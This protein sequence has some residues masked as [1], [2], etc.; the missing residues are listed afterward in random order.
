VAVRESYPRLSHRY[1]KLKARWF[2][3]EELRFGIATPHCPR[4]TIAEF[5]GPRR[6]RPCYP[7][8]SA[9]SPEMAAVADA[10]LR[11]MDRRAGAAG[12]GVGRLCGIRRCEAHPY[13]LSITGR[14]RD[15]MTLAH[16]ARHG[17][18]QLLRTA[19]LSDGRHTVDLAETVASSSFAG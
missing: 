2:G 6:R 14:V 16:G 3:V 18:H 7:L 9:F 5:H 13:L 15:V 1:Y 8:Y 11:A 4:K 19:R 12:Q 10:F 17:V